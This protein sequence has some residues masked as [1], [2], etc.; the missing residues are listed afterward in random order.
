[1][2]CRRAFP[3]IENASG[4]DADL[5]F[6]GYLDAE[7]AANFKERGRIELGYSSLLRDQL[8]VPGSRQ[9]ARLTPKPN[10]LEAA[11]KGRSIGLR[12]SQQSGRVLV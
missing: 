10:D 1:L 12:S 2:L 9:N 7:C 3:R 11:M 5:K 4:L 8:V 6:V